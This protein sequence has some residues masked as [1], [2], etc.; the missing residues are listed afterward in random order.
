MLIYAYDY[1][2]KDDIKNIFI[3]THRKDLSIPSDKELIVIKS[4]NG[5]SEIK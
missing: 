4:S 3:V 2:Q 1:L 5:I